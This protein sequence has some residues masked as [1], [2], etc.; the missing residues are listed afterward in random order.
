MKMKMTTITDITMRLNLM[1]VEIFNR[2]IPDF[3]GSHCPSTFDLV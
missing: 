1:L 3:A 2:Y